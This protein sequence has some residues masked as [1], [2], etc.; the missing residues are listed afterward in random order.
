ME[1]DAGNNGSLVVFNPETEIYSGSFNELMLNKF[2]NE[3]VFE[4]IDSDGDFTNLLMNHKNDFLS[5]FAFGVSKQ[6]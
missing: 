5:G 1:A 2:I 4:V 6:S 3:G